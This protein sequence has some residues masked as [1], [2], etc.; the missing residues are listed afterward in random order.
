[1]TAALRD[2]DI[3][4]IG[5][6]CVDRLKDGLSGVCTSL[7]CLNQLFELGGSFLKC[8][9]AGDGFQHSW[10]ERRDILCKSADNGV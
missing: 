4:G 8:W 5:V 6:E 3:L 2:V 1:M 7:S 9:I 10:R